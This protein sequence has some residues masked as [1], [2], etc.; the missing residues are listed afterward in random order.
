MA[1]DPGFT[2]ASGSDA[3]LNYGWD[4]SSEWVI[5]MDQ[6]TWGDSL[7]VFMVAI[8]DD[9][10][11]YTNAY[12]NETGGGIPVTIMRSA[13]DA[14]ENLSVSNPTP[15]TLDLNWTVSAFNGGKDLTVDQTVYMSLTSNIDA[16]SSWVVDPH[17][18]SDTADT[19][20]RFTYY[21][22]W[23]S[24]KNALGESFTQGA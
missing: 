7:Y 11:S 4:D 13:P 23:V 3:G 10:A 17:A 12:P 24:A 5:H 15:S 21:Y 2:A 19:L 20:Q 22:F 9:G 18:H 8:N 16:A 6:S 1:T 14:P